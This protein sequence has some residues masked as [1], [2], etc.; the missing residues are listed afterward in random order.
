MSEPETAPSPVPTSRVRALNAAEANRTGTYVLYWMTAARRVRH[1]FALQRAAEL[2]GDLGRPLVV[3]EALRAGYH[4]ASDRLHQFVIDGMRDNLAAFEAT[5]AHYYSYLEPAEGDGAGLVEALS[6]RACVVVTDDY[7]ASFIPKMLTATAPR[8]HVRLEG[9]DG[10]GLYP[11]RLATQPFSSAY[12]FRRTLQRELAPHVAPDA[13]PR[14]DPFEGVT[15]PA[16][17]RDALAAIEARWSR[18]DLDTVDLAALPIDHTL[19]PS[20]L[21]GGSAAARER[22]DAF[23][24]GSLQRYG[25]GRNHPDDEDQSGL[26]PYLHFGHIGT[27]EVFAGVVEHEDWRPE[28]LSGDTRGRKAGWWGMSPGAESFLDEVVTWRELGFNA[29]VQDPEG[30]DRYESIPEWARRTLE[31]HA[32]DPRERYT[33]EELA[34]GQTGDEVWNAAQRQ[35]LREGR[36]HNY[37]RMVWGKRILEWTDGPREALATMV[38]LNNRYALDGRDPNS[39]SGILWCLGKYDRPWGPERPVFGTVRYMSSEN[40]KRKLRMARYL[41]RFGTASEGEQAAREL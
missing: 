24:A 19:A 38:E 15:L 1:N 29:C 36:I 6:E 25:Q 5:P 32:S 41:E 35:L 34:A 37:L 12:Q 26:S 11:M 33:L 17:D 18:A 8:L 31:A 10:N 13:R 9:V 22:L 3:L 30:Y 4:W 27:H 21:R 16:L 39:Y 23:L 20:P 14:P 40:T 7:P 28:H 2:A